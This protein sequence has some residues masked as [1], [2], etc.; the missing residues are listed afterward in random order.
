MSDKLP[1]CP[2]TPKQVPKSRVS[3]HEY[4][5]IMSEVSNIISVCSARYPCTSEWRYITSRR[6]LICSKKLSH[7]CNPWCEKK[8]LVS[9]T[10]NLFSKKCYAKSVKLLK[11]TLHQETSTRFSDVRDAKAQ[12]L[13]AA[14]DRKFDNIELS[15]PNRR[16]RRTDREYWDERKRLEDC[17]NVITVLIKP[18][19]KNGEFIDKFSDLVERIDD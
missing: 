3:T 10:A 13:R 14:V 16:L 7:Q 5:P 4:L 18:L 17:Y 19:S 9:V 6:T 1:A 8:W 11:P 2:K 15:L 12:E